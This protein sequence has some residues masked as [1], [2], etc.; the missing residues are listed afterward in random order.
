MLPG[1]PAVCILDYLSGVDGLPKENVL[2]FVYAS[3]SWIAVRPSGTE[4]K[5]KVYYSICSGDGAAAAEALT[6]ARKAVADRI[7]FM[8][9]GHILEQAAPHQFFESPRSQRARQFLA[10]FSYTTVS[11]RKESA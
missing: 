2:K 10:K 8:D 5:L 6:G 4:P 1:D 3:G 9:G 7:V 11:K